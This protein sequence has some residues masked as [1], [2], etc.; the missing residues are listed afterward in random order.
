[1]QRDPTSPRSET[2]ATD[3]RDWAAPKPSGL[4]RLLPI[5]TWLPSY[6]RT[7]VRFDLIAGATLWGLL[8]PESIAYAGLAGL[9]AQAGLYTLLATLAAYVVFGTSR[10][11]VVAATSAAA[12][13]LATAAASVGPVNADQYAAN[14][15][16]VVLFCAGLLLLAGLLHLGFIAQFLSRPVMEGFVFG[17][18]IFVTVKQLPKLF[19]VPKGEGN[20]VQQLVHLITHLGDTSA[21]TL[22][23][24]AGALGLLVAVERF[25]PR[26][27]GGLLVLIL[28]IGISTALNLAQ[29]GVAT[30]GTVPSGLPSVGLP[31]IS[32]GDIATL[33]AAAAGMVLVIFSESLGA[34]QA[35]ATK[36]GYEIDPN[37]E[38]IAL[39]V[40]NAG[41]ASWAA[42][43]AAGACPNLPST[44]AQGPGPSFHRSLQPV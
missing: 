14:A 32:A 26:V 21:V 40:A 18:A 11:L 31:D 6:D 27:P 12:V 10:H 13:L 43:P 39:G 2:A 17:L 15:A 8:V 44:K 34:A 3:P 30:V 38:L 36:Y 29:H 20:S 19:G 42:W 28:G 35:F 23:I 16:A 1:M 4:H 37:Q 41:S 25:A 22:A 24:G 5:L 7:S 9:P 33:L